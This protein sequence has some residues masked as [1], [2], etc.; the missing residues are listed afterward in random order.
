VLTIE[1]DDDVRLM[2]KM[3]LEDEGFD[4][5]EAPTAFDGLARFAADR[6]DLVLVDL[7]LPDRSG[8]DVCRALRETSGVPII[9]LTANE[10]GNDVVTGLDAG[11]DDYVTKPFDHKILA[12]RIRALLRRAQGV[13]D[14]TAVATAAAHAALDQPVFDQP[15]SGGQPAIEQPSTLDPTDAANVRVFGELSINSLVGD[16]RLSGASVHLTKTELRLLLLLT[17]EPG[18]VFSREEL[19]DQ[20]WGYD[21]VADGRLVDV[22]VRRLRT[23]V[24]VDPAEPRHILTAR[25]TGYRFV[26]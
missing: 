15:E 16:V 18:R 21:E 26:P 20:V 11:A 10:A 13:P 14:A 2:L 3:S 1:D 4:V 12:A 8:F 5:S 24:E 7:K 17:Q 23:K 9:I 25:G 19:L 6:P 22:H